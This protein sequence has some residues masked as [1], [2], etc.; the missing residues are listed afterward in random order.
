MNI[1]QAQNKLRKLYEDTSSSLGNF[2]ETGNERAAA[3]A[4]Q[5][6]KTEL[7]EL[8]DFIAQPIEE[9]TAEAFREM[10]EELE[11]VLGY[12]TP[13]IKLETNVHDTEI[14]YWDGTEYH[15]VD[16][17]NDVVPHAI[18]TVKERRLEVDSPNKDL[19]I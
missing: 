19:P 6:I 18:Q 7:G 8:Q 12:P 14:R 15:T 10:I 2:L 16:S 4:L 3:A 13:S 9:M 1:R 17:L 5:S 11:K